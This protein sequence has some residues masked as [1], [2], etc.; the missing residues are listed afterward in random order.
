MRKKQDIFSRKPTFKKSKS[1]NKIKCL[2]CD[3]EFMSKD[4][5]LNRLCDNCKEAIKSYNTS[6]YCVIG[7]KEDTL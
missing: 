6:Y 1:S 2:K 3:K 7:Y 5:I 4:K